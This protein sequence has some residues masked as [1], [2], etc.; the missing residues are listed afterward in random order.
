MNL[1]TKYAIHCPNCHSEIEDFDHFLGLCDHC[2]GL[3][4]PAKKH[5]E[6]VRFMVE[7]A[8]GCV[9]SLSDYKKNHNGHLPL[10]IVGGEYSSFDP[11]K[12]LEIDC[13][14]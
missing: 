12:S 11:N 5:A 7:F 4:K 2:L 3:D 9:K 10:T 14:E 6:E 8:A 1:I 13:R